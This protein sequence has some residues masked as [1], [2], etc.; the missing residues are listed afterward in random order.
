MPV[1]QGHVRHLLVEVLFPLLVDLEVG[2]GDA[3]RVDG[4]VE[5]DGEPLDL[6]AIL[7]RVS[8]LAFQMNKYKNIYVGKGAV[9]YL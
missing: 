3:A 1:H 7:E 8:D 4:R 2:H 6:A 5:G 9:R